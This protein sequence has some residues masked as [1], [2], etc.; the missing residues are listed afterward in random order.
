[1]NTMRFAYLSNPLILEATTTAVTLQQ[2]AVEATPTGEI[3]PDAV[4]TWL[5]RLRLLEGVPFAHLVPDSE[6]LPLESI[7]FFYLDREWTDTLVQGALSVGTVNS[8]DRENL[9]A[10][11]RPIRDEVDT[12]ERKVRLV[13]SDPLGT[14]P[15]DTISGF[16]LRSRVVSGWPA[17]HVRGYRTEIGPDDVVLKEADPRRLRL[18]RLERLAPAVLLCLFDGIPSVVHIEEPRQGVQFGVKLESGPQG[19]KKVTLPLRDVTTAERLDK[20]QPPPKGAKEVPVP[21]RKGAPG[22]INIAEL[23][24][25]IAD[26]KATHIN[27]FESAGVQSAEFA[28]EMLRFPY[29]QVFGDPEK[30]GGANLPPLTFADLF[31]PLIKI[32]TVRQWNAGK[33]P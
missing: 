28:L 20:I 27:D 5:A 9:Q 13:G 17:L 32:D 18:L 2:Q 31:R 15:V 7:R 21:F 30:G 29:R 10:L 16:L 6:L 1:M 4:R 26:Q 19:D 23:A 12:E 24:K 11:Y 33:Q 14:A 3:L 22:V 25:R 8:L